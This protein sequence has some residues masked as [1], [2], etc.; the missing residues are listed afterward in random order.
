MKIY[1]LVIDENN[2]MPVTAISLVYEPAI[3]EYAMYFNK[4]DK[5]MLFSLDN[6]QQ[7]ITGPIM[8][9]NKNIFRSNDSDG[10]YVFFSVLTVKKCMEMFMSNKLMDS[11]NI[12]HSDNGIGSMS[13]IESWI[14]E[15]QSKDK[16]AIYGYNLPVGT[17][18]GSFKV[19]DLEVWE[20]IKNHELNGF[21]I[22]CFMN[23]MLVRMGQQI[24]ENHLTELSDIEL[25]DELIRLLEED[26][27]D[28]LD[29]LNL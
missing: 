5:K 22:E 13:L 16:S 23:Q 19:N 24:L 18:F 15:D 20:K 21:S 2:T 7:I 26:D 14:V 10:Y 6:D 27:S 8:I 29:L 12:D 17:W 9:P 28:L 3:E 11:T 1:E 4:D 25:V